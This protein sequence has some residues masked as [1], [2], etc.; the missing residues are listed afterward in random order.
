MAGGQGHPGSPGAG[1]RLFETAKSGRGG[2]SLDPYLVRPFRWDKA[3]RK[4]ARVAEADGPEVGP[5]QHLPHV[6]TDG[7]FAKEG[8]GMGFAGYGVWFGPLDPRN[9][10]LP[11]E[12]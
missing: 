3:G 8:P 2:G 7:S 9:W 1:S 4:R 5:S 10:A 12:G 11:L 6:Y